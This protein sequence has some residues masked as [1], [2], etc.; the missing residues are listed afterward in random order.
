M[1]IQLLAKSFEKDGKSVKIN[2]VVKKVI[3]FKTQNQLKEFTLLSKCDV[4][5]YL[6]K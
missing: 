1:P 6:K 3:E 2:L 5:F 4:V